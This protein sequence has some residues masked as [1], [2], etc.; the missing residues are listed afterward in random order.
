M[1]Q[2]AFHC[3]DCK[4]QFNVQHPAPNSSLLTPR[5]RPGFSPERSRRGTLEIFPLPA[6]FCLSLSLRKSPAPL[7]KFP[8]QSCV[9]LPD[10]GKYR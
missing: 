10:W 9:A 5:P 1:T 4:Q 2:Y 3:W 7:L 8:A 6:A